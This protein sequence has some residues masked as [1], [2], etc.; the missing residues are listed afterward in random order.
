[1]DPRPGTFDP[2]LDLQ[3]R[4][5][6]DSAEPIDTYQ[7]LVANPFLALFGWLAGVGL[8][9]EALR[10]ANLPLFLIAIA[11]FIASVFLLQFHCLDCG[12]T[13]WLPRYQ[14]HA[15]PA[16]LA[17]QANARRRRF[18]GPGLKT[19]LIG[20]FV[21]MSIVFVLGMLALAARR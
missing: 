15:C 19:Q 7:R 21:V 18:R 17:R 8:L 3:P 2:D 16:V 12:A 20:W 14:R 11:V 4:F 13:R 1:L 10:R 6:S 5:T 9:R